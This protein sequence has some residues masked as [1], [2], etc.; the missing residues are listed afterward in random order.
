MKILVIGPFPNPITGNSLSNQVIFDNLP[1]FHSDIEIRK[2]NTSY[3]SFKENLG[4]LSLFKLWHYTKQYFNIFKIFNCSKV[5]FTSGQTFYGVLKYLP[6]LLFAKLL[7]KE[8]IVHIHGNYLHKEYDNLKSFKK[9]F[10]KKTLELC[11]KG[12]VLSKS[13]RINLTPFMS[14]NRIFEVENFV[15][16]FLFEKKNDKSYDKLRIIYLSNLMTEKGIFDLLDSFKLL[17]ENNIDFEAKVAGGIDLDLKDKIM[18]RLNNTSSNIDYLGLVYGEEKKNLLD[19]GNVFVF[20]TYYAMEGQPISIFEAM[21]T[22]NIIVTTKH[23]GIPDVFE[24][25]INGF[26]VDKKSPESIFNK[27]HFISKDLN[28]YQVISKKNALEAFEKY[29]VKI[30]I[31][32]LYNIFKYVH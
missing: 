20:P 12:V 13:L 2:I 10:L 30:F 32:K 17:N 29:K 6:Y 21:A 9:F 24:E 14:D 3:S 19:W 8:I 1:K 22:G 4:E 25:G 31:D 11:D 27:L 16:D 28:K 26:Y 18:D 15:Q 5:Y 23:A 7:R